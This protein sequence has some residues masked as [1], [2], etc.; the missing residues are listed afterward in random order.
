MTLLG[1]QLVYRQVTEDLA[2]GDVSP[3]SCCVTMILFDVATQ[4]S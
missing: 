1:L 4:E 2:G 3:T